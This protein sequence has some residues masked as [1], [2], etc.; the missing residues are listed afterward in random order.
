MGYD[1]C[2]RRDWRRILAPPDVRHVLKGFPVTDYARHLIASMA[3]RV[4]PVKGQ[5]LRGRLARQFLPYCLASTSG[6]LLPLN[7]SYKPIGWPIDWVGRLDYEDPQFDGLRLPFNR[8]DVG[9]LEMAVG[10][11]GDIFWH[12]Y[13][14]G[15]PPPWESIEAAD[16]YVVDLEECFKIRISVAGAAGFSGDD[17]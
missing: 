9:G 13:G 3:A 2:A 7:R 8:A 16:R 5:R 12:L 4:L 6:G 14:R 15:S 10:D 17:E 11:D 1:Y